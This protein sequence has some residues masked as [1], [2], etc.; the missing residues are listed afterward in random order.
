[1]SAKTYITL[2]TLLLLNKLSIAQNINEDNIYYK[3][4]K[5]YSRYVE[6][7]EPETDTVYFE[8]IKGITSYF[9]K[10]ISGIKVVIITALNQQEIYSAN[11]GKLI[12][13]KMTPAQ[14][15]E[16]KIDVSII[17]YQGQYS[18]EQGGLR[19]GLSKWHSVIFVYDIESKS[20][21]YKEIQNNG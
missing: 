18:Q 13:R 20:F 6:R 8:E 1:M 16:D 14:V 5:E 3:A 11:G 21:K 19:L 7:F 9:P 4:L 17:P 10:E 2:I 15:V 12:H